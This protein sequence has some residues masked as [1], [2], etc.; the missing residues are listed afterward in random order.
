MDKETEKKLVKVCEKLSEVNDK[1]TEL[2]RQH[3][4]VHYFGLVGEERNSLKVYI[5]KKKAELINIQKGDMVNV[6]ISKPSKRNF[7]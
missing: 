7:K 4:M 1:T 6:F 5:P 2:E 3:G